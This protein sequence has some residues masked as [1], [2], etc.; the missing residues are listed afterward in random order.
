MSFAIGPR[1]RLEL[2]LR[3]EER[4]KRSSEEKRAFVA[5]LRDLNIS[6]YLQRRNHGK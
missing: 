5:R 3:I 6:I 4:E 2:R 1:E